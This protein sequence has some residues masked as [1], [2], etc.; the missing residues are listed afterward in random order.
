M[1]ILEDDD[2]KENSKQV[3]KFDFFRYN[4][5]LSGKQFSEAME[6][7]VRYSEAAL[8]WQLDAHHLK[9]QIKNMLYHFL[10][11]LLL[12]EEERE[13]Y[14]YV[15]FGEVATIL[16]GGWIMCN[17][18]ENEE[19]SG[20]W[21]VAPIP[22]VSKNENAVAASNVGG[23]SWYV[24]KNSANPV[25]ATDFMVSMFGE[26]DEFIDSLIGEIGLIPA[27]KNPT[28]YSN[29]EADD[30][31]FGGQQVTKILTRMADKIPTV[32]YGSKT[33]EIENILEEEFQSAL[34]DGNLRGC[35]ERAQIKVEAVAKE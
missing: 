16:S 31:F 18:K 5:L 2:K 23:S 11:F 10:D 3:G 28:V 27:V 19:Q 1:L 30:E 17:I 21:R 4:Q 15:F 6:L 34:A 25:K 9:N 14:R 35:L 12:E 13:N 20:L 26:N 24:L 8:E 33:Y 7:L 22:V 32:N 29:Y